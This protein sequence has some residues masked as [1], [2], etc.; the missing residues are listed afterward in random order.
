MLDLDPSSEGTDSPRT[1]PE[2]LLGPQRF[3]KK[4]GRWGVLPSSGLPASCCVPAGVAAVQGCGCPVFGASRPPY[5]LALPGCRWG[6]GLVTWFLLSLTN[7]GMLGELHCAAPAPRRSVP[8]ALERGS[9]GHR[10]S[11]AAG[12][13]TGGSAAAATLTARRAR[14]SVVSPRPVTFPRGHSRLCCRGVV[15]WRSHVWIYSAPGSGF[16]SQ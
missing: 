5:H 9:G 16:E 13:S 14:V 11:G 12:L 15:Q 3:P 8:R 10:L 1:S 4:T 7:V 2:L 6:S